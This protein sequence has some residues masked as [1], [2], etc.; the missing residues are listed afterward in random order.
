MDPEEFLALGAELPYSVGLRGSAASADGAFDVLLRGRGAT[1]EAFFPLFAQQTDR[2]KIW[3][4]YANN[5]LQGLFSQKLAPQLRA[6][7]QGR[8]PEHMTPAHFVLLDTLPLTPSGKLNRRALPP[9]DAL[10][11]RLEGAY[12][13]PRTP[14]EEMLAEIWT[15]ILGVKQIGIHDHFF[16]ELGGH[17]LLAT[18]LVSR[19]RDSFQVEL[20]LRQIF[21]MPTIAG[22]A[23]AIEETRGRGESRMVRITPV[24]RTERRVQVSAG[25]VLE[26]LN[27]GDNGKSEEQG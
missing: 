17:S 26:I 1:A 24:V 19:V 22:L 4:R 18:Q 20:P 3:S 16:S 7:L 23:A 27:A 21:E 13:A 25:G 6:F 12:V 15:Q 11:P 10:R 5:P 9:P 2:P 8:L 14:V